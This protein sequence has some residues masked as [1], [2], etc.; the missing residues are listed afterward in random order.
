MSVTRFAPA[1]RCPPTSSSWPA[2][3]RDHDIAAT[4]RPEGHKLQEV[5]R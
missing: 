4:G 3:G 5:R 1:T 2:G